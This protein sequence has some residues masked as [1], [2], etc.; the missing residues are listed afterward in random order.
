MLPLKF[1]CGPKERT[2]LEGD[3]YSAF[4]RDYKEL[5]AVSSFCGIC[6]WAGWWIG[7]SICWRSST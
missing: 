6:T 2:L 5:L 4:P 3:Y 1:F 7:W